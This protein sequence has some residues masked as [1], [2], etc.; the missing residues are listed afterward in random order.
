MLFCSVMLLSPWFSLW[1]INTHYAKRSFFPDC[2]NIIYLFV[3][4][5]LHWC[6]SGYYIPD[7][8]DRFIYTLLHHFFLWN[9]RSADPHYEVMEILLF[10]PYNTYSTLMNQWD[11]CL[12]NISLE[13][14]IVF[15]IMFLT[16]MLHLRY[17]HPV[18]MQIQVYLWKSLK[19][20]RYMYGLLCTN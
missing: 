14:R 13:S 18:I 2:Y 6:Y 3:F 5:H 8:N 16:S 17:L 19:H 15:L 1:T 4:P 10:P 7:N 20:K 11:I 9:E 12:S